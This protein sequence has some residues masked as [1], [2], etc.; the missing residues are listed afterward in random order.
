[1]THLL[2]HSPGLHKKHITTKQLRTSNITT[3]HL[4]AHTYRSKRL[5]MPWSNETKFNQSK[6]KRKNKTKT[7]KVERKKNSELSRIS[8]WNQRTLV[9]QGCGGVWWGGFDDEKILIH[10]PLLRYFR[11]GLRCGTALSRRKPSHIR[12]NQF[13]T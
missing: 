7:V 10:P 4:L 9:K 13:F 1:M 6:W 3:F 11:G 12:K 5:L 8:K 2:A